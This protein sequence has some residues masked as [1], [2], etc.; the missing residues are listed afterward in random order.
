M[1]IEFER[2]GG[3]AGVVLRA[4]VDAADLGPE[5]AAALARLPQVAR[6]RPAPGADRFQY[7]LEVVEGASRTG[8]VF[9]ESEVTPELRPLLYLLT[10][11]A[12]R[13]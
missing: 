7:R 1:R 6:G 3:V 4:A 9:D 8:Y 12:L 10:E 2:S 13:R 5:A 11:H